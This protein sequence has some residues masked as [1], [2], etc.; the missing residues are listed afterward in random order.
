M[1]PLGARRP[2]YLVDAP[3]ASRWP[4]SATDIPYHHTLSHFYVCLLRPYRFK[5]HVFRQ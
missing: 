4:L 5:R 2:M 1:G 3:I